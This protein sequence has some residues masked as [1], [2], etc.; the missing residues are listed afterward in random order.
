LTRANVIQLGLAF[1]LFGGICYGIFIAF[2]IDA[3]KAGIASEA[4]LVFIVLLWSGSYFVRVLT[5]KM[6][7]MEQRKRYRNAYE[8]I[9]EAKLNEKYESMSDKDKINLIKK[10]GL[11]KESD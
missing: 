4:L 8:K 2:G 5:G 1:F 11:D 3:T 6:T 10:L 7:F 9:S